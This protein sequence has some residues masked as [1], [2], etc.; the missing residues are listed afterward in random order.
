MEQ[1]D[2]LRE[3]EDEL[4]EQNDRLEE[5]AS[6]VSHDLRN[7]LN[8]AQGR[9][10]L[11]R[12]ECDSDH[13]T[14]AVQAHERMET[15]IEDLLML[16]RDGE[17]TTKLEDVVLADIIARCWQNVETADATL[18]IDTTHTIRADHTRLQQLFENLI[19][20]AVEHGGT[21]VTIRTGDLGDGFYIED[22][23]PG[24]PEETRDRIFEAG[25]TTTDE[26]TG[27]GL[28]I[29]E[30]IAVSHGWEITVIDA[31]NGGARFE[32]TGVTLAK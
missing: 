18:H 30:E 27:Y 29:V 8:V 23:G 32:I 12:E 2:E 14:A 7:P 3:R 13:L 4:T 5:F 28:Q 19:R 22:D 15:L 26:G 1:T 10:E 21:D 16:A 20:N 24:I 31:D 17:T 11:A 25:Y 9:V 6:I